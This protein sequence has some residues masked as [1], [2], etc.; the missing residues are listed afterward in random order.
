MPLHT[1]RPSKQGGFSHGTAFH[2]LPSGHSAMSPVAHSD[3]PS[4]SLRLIGELSLQ[5]R[6]T[7]S[8]YLSGRALHC[9]SHRRAPP[10]ETHLIG[11]LSLQHRQTS[12]YYLSGR[13]L[14]C[15]SHRRAPPHETHLI[16]EL[17]PQHR[18]TSSYRLCIVAHNDEPS[19][20]L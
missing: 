11:E 14:H 20:S 2:T 1:K 13:A 6:Q 9:I 10:H 4:R 12:S 16:G 8:Y 15:I 3:E 19:R 18:Q 17:S 5:H 7:S